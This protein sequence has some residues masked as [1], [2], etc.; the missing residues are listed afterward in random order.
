MPK[1]RYRLSDMEYD[2]ISLV[3]KGANQDSL[4]TIAKRAT[5]EENMPDLFFQ[6]GSVVNQE[7]LEEGD[8]VYDA[9]GNAYEYTTEVEEAEEKEPELVGKSAF[10][11]E[12]PKKEP[13]TKTAKTFGSELR[14]ELSKAFSDNDR[15]AVITKAFDQI[16]KMQTMIE[17]QAEIA[18][19]ER[20]LRLT[21]EYISK[22]A[23][24]NLPVDADELGPVLYRMA[25]TMSYEDCAVINKCLSAS[26]EMLFTEV[27]YQG[28]GDNQ[29]VMSAVERHAVEIGKSADADTITGIFD[30][31]PAAYDE[32]LASQRGL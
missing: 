19:S 25:E 2:E 8:V 7:A 20:D 23:E 4:V 17:K 32:Y 12:K 24:Y 29:D 27:G 1:Q 6:D 14:E 18:K 26:G 31:N 9:D 21:R 16:D 15:D 10:F 11:A 22:A 3:D 28:G 5:E 30:Q 13:V